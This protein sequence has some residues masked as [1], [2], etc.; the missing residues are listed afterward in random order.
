M[1]TDQH[2]EPAVRD[3]SIVGFCRRQLISRSS[4]YNMKAAGH[5][6]REYLVGKLI[7]ISA[8]AEAAWVRAREIANDAR[9]SQ[10]AAYKETPGR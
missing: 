2:Y 8:D 10:V 4:Y 9:R 3:P 7:R 1:N 5:G 6:P